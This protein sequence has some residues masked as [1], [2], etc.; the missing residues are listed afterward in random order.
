M[1]HA[2]TAPG[3][4]GLP[5]FGV[6]RHLI[7]GAPVY[8]SHLADTYGPFARFGAFGNT[9]YLISDPELVRE[10]LVTQAANFPK[11]DRDVKI[12]DR[13][14]G[15]GL[16]SSNGEEHKR[17]R[18]LTQPA[19]HTR[20]IDAYAGVMVD[21]TEAMLDEW[22]D[23]ATMDVN[24]T[25]RELTMYIVARSLFGADR[26]AMRDTAERIG[27]AIHVI[28]AIADKE[29]QSPFLLPD[30]LPTPTNRRRQEATGVLYETIDRLIAERRATAVDGQIQDTGDLLSMLLLSRDESG[31][32]MS[33]QE[34]R[35][36][37]VTLFVAGHE[38]TSNALTWAWYLLSQHPEVEERLHEEVDAVLGERPPALSDLPRLPYTMQVIKEAMRLYPPAW[39]INVRRAAADTTLGGY[40]LRRG[41]LLWI[42]PYV[43]HRRPAYF[44][45]PERFDPDRWTPE[46]ERALPKFAYM[47][48]GGGPRICI[49]NGFALMEAHLIVAAVARRYRLRLAPS[50]AI[51]L[52]A[53][54][55]LSNHGGMHMIAE[56][57][58]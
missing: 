50:Q 30:W 48:F 58:H 55:T 3:P 52:N 38:T 15:H 25:M 18:R 56:S 39:V 10:A 35:D 6:A 19:F 43:M 54:I 29:F 57:R 13:V 23:G 8:T 33:D 2:N 9:F 26:V 49:G 21:Y 36:Q 53:Q 20:R 16:V 46:R 12:L 11:D 7:A 22:G 42:S 14:I 44:P 1:I 40:Q 27:Q 5:F 31:D 17:Q 47:P 24:E 32:R 4:K 28:Q 41:E 51:A 37:L 34:V 45:D